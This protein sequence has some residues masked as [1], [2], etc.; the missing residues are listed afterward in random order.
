MECLSERQRITST[1]DQVRDASYNDKKNL[2]TSEEQINKFLDNI[3]FFKNELA[4]K[5]IEIEEFTEKLE[6]FTW[7]DHV[8]DECLR[9]LN[10]LIAATRDWRSTLIKLYVQMQSIK[11]R[12]IAVVEIS[13]FKCALDD[14]RETCQDLESVFFHLPK[15]EE[16]QETTKQLSLV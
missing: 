15:S 5:T 11:K 6:T 9:L 2:L 1:V 8:D 12:K 16:F 14:L 4:K 10:D 7:F 13:S 3:I